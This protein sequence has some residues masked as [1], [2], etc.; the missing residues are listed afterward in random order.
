MTDLAPANFNATA[1][2]YVDDW[3]HVYDGLLWIVWSIVTARRNAHAMY[4]LRDVLLI[5]CDL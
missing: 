3:M 1:C 2:M 4:Q 5:L